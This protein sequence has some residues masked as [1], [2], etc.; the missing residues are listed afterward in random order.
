[1]MEPERRLRMELSWTTDPKDPDG[2]GTIERHNGTRVIVDPLFVPRQGDL[3][4]L[5]DG[6]SAEMVKN[7]CLSADGQTAYVSFGTRYEV[8]AMANAELLDLGARGWD[9]R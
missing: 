3:I 6:W 1:M 2:S 7:V 4:E 9:V 8:S 5:A